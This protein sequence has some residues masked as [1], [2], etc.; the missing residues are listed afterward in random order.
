MTSTSL[1]ACVLVLVVAAATDIKTR[2]I[3]NIVTLGGLALGL[4]I[5]V[6]IG[7]VDDGLF[8]GLR[9]LAFAIVGVVAC[10][11]V[12]F[13]AWRRGEMGGGDV[14]LFAA[15]G[16]LAGPVIGF[17]VQAITFLISLLVLFP[18]NLV[19][20]GALHVALANVRVGMTNVLRRREARAAYVAGPKLPPVILAP[21]IGLAFLISVLRHG[22]L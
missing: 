3:P 15:M 6:A 14:K 20:H 9:G 22:V 2:N 12:P 11:V 8:G 21:T 16:S 13:I 18:W 4:A 5:H 7:V 19:R 17:D 10:S 1:L